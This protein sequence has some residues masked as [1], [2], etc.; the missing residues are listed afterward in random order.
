MLEKGVKSLG[1]K[2]Q[3]KCLNLFAQ[4]CISVLPLVA[5]LCYAIK[6]DNNRTKT[7]KL[8]YLN[9]MQFLVQP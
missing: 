6:S 1:Q 8:D 5:H 2:E 9:T 3:L 7:I 4:E